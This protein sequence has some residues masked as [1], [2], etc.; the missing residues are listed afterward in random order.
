MER[1]N[2]IEAAPF[3]R[4]PEHVYPLHDLSAATDNIVSRSE[5]L[6][7]ETPY[8][9]QGG[10]GLLDGGDSQQNAIT[11]KREWEVKHV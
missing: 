11:M 6:E 4:L 2:D 3:K 5:D 9:G 10:H 1:S 7:Y 8:S